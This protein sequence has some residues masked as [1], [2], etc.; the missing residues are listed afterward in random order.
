[1]TGTFATQFYRQPRKRLCYGPEMERI[2]QLVEKDNYAIGQ[3]EKK[4]AGQKKKTRHDRA[5]PNLF[6]LPKKKGHDSFSF[7]Q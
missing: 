3:N 6:C 5:S 4:K 1:M 2:L 7:G